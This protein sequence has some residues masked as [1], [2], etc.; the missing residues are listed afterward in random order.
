MRT[1]ITLDP[2]VAAVVERIR[3][4]RGIGLSEAVN[5]LIRTGLT[6]RR[7]RRAFRQRSARIGLRIDVTNVAEALEQL[8]GLGAR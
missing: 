1:T 6:T 7:P 3:R 5:E 2:D 8:D 4:E